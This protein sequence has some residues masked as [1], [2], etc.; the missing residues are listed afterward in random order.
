[1]IM[2]KKKKTLTKEEAENHL[3]FCFWLLPLFIQKYHLPSI[4]LSIYLSLYLFIY[5]SIHLSI[6]LWTFT[7]EQYTMNIYI[8]LCISMYTYI[9]TC[10]HSKKWR[11]LASFTDN[12]H[13]LSKICY[14]G[15]NIFRGR[16]FVWNFSLFFIYFWI[17]NF[18]CYYFTFTSV[19]YSW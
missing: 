6:Y 16:F 9:H 13:L 2:K 4:Y 18:T 8:Y 7:C 11:T 5:T 15:N 1:M 12:F 17:I 3:G 10:S 19:T 14:Y